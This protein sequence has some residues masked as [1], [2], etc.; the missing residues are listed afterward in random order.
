[1][2][3]SVSQGSSV[4]FWNAIPTRTGSAPTSRP[5]TST[6]PLDALISPVTSLRMVDLPQP[7]GPTSAMKSP[8]SMRRSV[9]SSAFTC[10]SPR[11]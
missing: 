2:S 5:A 3:R 11:P 10:L 6:P 1:L 4:G 7:D 8:C 9:A